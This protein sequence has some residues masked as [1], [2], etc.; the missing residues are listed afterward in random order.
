[1]LFRVMIRLSFH[2]TCHLCILAIRHSC[3]MGTKC[4]AIPTSV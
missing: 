2:L 4:R 1:M 3:Y